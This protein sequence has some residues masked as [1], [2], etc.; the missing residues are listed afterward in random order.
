MAISFNR[1]AFAR[2][3]TVFALVVVFSLI[4]AAFVHYGALKEAAL[5]RQ[6]RDMV[7]HGTMMR[8]RLNEMLAECRV[9]RAEASAPVLL[10]A[11]LE[12]MMEELSSSARQL[13]ESW[14]LFG[15]VEQAADAK[16][17][18][19]E[20]DHAMTRLIKGASL[21]PERIAEVHED[22]DTLHKEFL[23]LFGRAEH[24]I[25]VRIR[26]Y[27]RWVNIGNVFLVLTCV[28]ALIG[29]LMLLSDGLNVWFGPT[30]I[31][32]QLKRIENT[33]EFQARIQKL[34]ANTNP[35]NTP[36]KLHLVRTMQEHRTHTPFEAEALRGEERI[37]LWGKA[38][39]WT[40]LVKGM[41]RLWA[42][43]FGRATWEA[44]VLM[45][46]AGMNSPF[47]V[48]WSKTKRGPIGAGSL[49]LIE[50]IGEVDS[51]K[52]FL[53][54][55]F[56]LLD[57]EAR[58]RF[59]HALGNT[60]NQLHHIGL[61]SFKPRYLHMRPWAPADAAQPAFYLFDLDK[62][63]ICRTPY[64]WL[65]RFCSW[66]DN[67]RLLRQLRQYLTPAELQACAALLRERAKG[68]A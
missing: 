47:P 43:A 4:A 61:H 39:T 3:V 38:Y 66:R 63:G 68:T 35:G 46:S 6:C 60:W 1:K 7:H 5:E 21:E 45:Y 53:T 54:G 19:A 14:G 9:A 52:S 33:R 51:A 17:D 48:I 34:A 42:P 22:L 10:R 58:E 36:W 8:I 25:D 67:A 49:L 65:H 57:A 16:T 55:E 62:V 27:D 32:T 24:A 18:L 31:E 26:S 44:F 29:L 64:G 20:L 13:E 30:D 40:G 12:E 2:R 37:L 50:H 28:F 41:Q 15:L 56:V 59:L 11:R 23:E